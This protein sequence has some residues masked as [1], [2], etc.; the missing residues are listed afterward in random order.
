LPERRL[1]HVKPWPH[2]PVEQEAEPPWLIDIL[3]PEPGIDQDKSVIALDQ[4]AVAA[5]GRR[6]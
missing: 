1:G 4:E 6:R 5:H 2:H 3:N